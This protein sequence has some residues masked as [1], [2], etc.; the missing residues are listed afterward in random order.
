MNT[1]HHKGCSDER[2]AE[3]YAVP[4][5]HAKFFCQGCER[6]NG[7]CNGSEVEDDLPEL[8]DECWLHVEIWREEASREM[9]ET[10]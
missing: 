7:W 2:C 8:C 5:G 10:A 3:A 1:K 4:V 6:W 9:K